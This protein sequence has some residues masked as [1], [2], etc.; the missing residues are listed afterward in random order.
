MDN[1]RELSADAQKTQSPQSS[2]GL[3][4]RSKGEHKLIQ[5]STKYSPAPV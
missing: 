5:A 1:Q 4:P 2:E 3:H